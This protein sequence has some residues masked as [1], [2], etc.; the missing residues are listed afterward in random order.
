[1]WTG[2]PGST[3]GRLI[4]NFRMEAQ[5]STRIEIESAFD[6]KLVNGEFGAFVQSVA[7]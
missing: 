6:Q 5:R 1:V 2:Y 3:D 4:R 7:S